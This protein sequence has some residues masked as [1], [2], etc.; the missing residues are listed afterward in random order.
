[1]PRPDYTWNEKRQ[2]WEK[3][4][5]KAD[6]KYTKLRSYGRGSL[7]ELR[8]LVRDFEIEQERIAPL[9]TGKSFSD[10]AEMWF[11]LA[12]AGKAPRTASN[13]RYYLSRRIYPVLGNLPIDS[14]KPVDIDRLIAENADKSRNAN[15][16]MLATV[17]RIM[18]Y[19]VENDFAQ[20]DVVGDKRAVGVKEKRKEALTRQQQDELLAAVD[21]TASEMLVKLCLFAGLRLSEACGLQ[22]SDVHLEDGYSYIHVCHALDESG[23]DP[24]VT[25]IL[26]TDAANRK[27]PIPSILEESL[28]R[29]A[30]DS[31][32]V[33]T[34][35][36]GSPKSTKVAYIILRKRVKRKQL[37]FSVHPHLLRHTYISELCAASAETG[38]DIKTIQ[39]LAGHS[40]PQI[41]LNIYAHV[42]Q[43]RQQ[44][45][46]DKVKKVFSGR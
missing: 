12:M 17:S 30:R 27:I 34:E 11:K 1:M 41:T 9:K 23:E 46:A 20:K 31:G 35:K 38:L 33:I 13:T 25:D 39:N 3:N 43:D 24:V 18:R 29:N 6:G 4:V 8:K 36:D 28:A 44:D 45:T 26:K 15:R 7:S 14:I 10:V 22:W 16:I 19:A 37:S 5:R 32:F 21:G 2:C 40:S 42:M